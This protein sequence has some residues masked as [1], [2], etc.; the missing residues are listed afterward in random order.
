VTNIKLDRSEMLST[1]S[2][3]FSCVCHIETILGG[4]RVIGDL[5]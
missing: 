3:E 5:K 4:N 2:L 1:N